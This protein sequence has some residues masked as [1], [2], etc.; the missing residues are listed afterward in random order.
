[1][2]ST[3]SESA[4]NIIL[5]ILLLNSLPLVRIC[6]SEICFAPAFT[7]NSC[8]RYKIPAERYQRTRFQPYILKPSIKMIKNV[9]LSLHGFPHAITHSTAR[10]N[11]TFLRGR[12]PCVSVNVTSI[13]QSRWQQVFRS[14]RLLCSPVNFSYV[15]PSRRLFSGE[16]RRYAISSL[17]SEKHAER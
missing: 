8:G 3:N 2:N 17:C 12:A 14:I 15:A 1:V 9:C 13:C 16:Y 5:F 6:S 4:Y 10:I 11:I 7:C